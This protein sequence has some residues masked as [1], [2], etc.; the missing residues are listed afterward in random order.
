VADPGPALILADGDVDSRAA[1]D[2]AWPGWA[3]G[4]VLV[5]AADGGA[6]HAAALGLRIDRWVGD[7]DSTD[8]AELARLRDLGADVELHDR[9]KDESDTE[10][11]INAAIAAGADAVTVLGAFGGA[12]LDH[13]LV[14]VTLLAHP[15]LGDRPASLLSASARVRLAQTTAKDASSLPLTVDLGGR[16]GDTV[17]IIPFGVDGVGIRTAGL[18]YPLRDETLVLG[19]ARGL[20]NVRLAADASFVLRGGA[21]LVVE[22]PATLS[23]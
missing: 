19:S 6:R 12:R 20:S 22:T 1:L 11:A 8:S 17:S 2:A 16:V 23:T 15:A 10:L 4:I 5:V 13:A 9:D 14:N 3:D 21:V 18:R 7:G